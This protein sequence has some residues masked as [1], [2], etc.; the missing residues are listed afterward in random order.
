MIQGHRYL[1]PPILPL[2][3]MHCW[4][5]T[6]K[7]F[8]IKSTSDIVVLQIG[9]ALISDYKS[10]F[11]YCVRSMSN[12][13]VARIR[14]IGASDARAGFPS[15][16]LK[17]A[18]SPHWWG[19][20]YHGQLSNTE[21]ASKCWGDRLFFFF[22]SHTGGQ[23]VSDLFLSTE[24]FLVVVSDATGVELFF[25][26]RTVS[27]SGSA[28]RFCAALPPSPFPFGGSCLETTPKKNWDL[29]IFFLE[30]LDGWSLSYMSGRCTGY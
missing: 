2:Q 29:T 14:L 23:P 13:N 27:D 7:F 5:S 19:K 24:P 15:Y 3:L 11:W 12:T 26:A 30:R 4:Q 18:E 9:R 8:V 6:S 17:H 10:V 28:R 22:P 1:E 25:L 21:Y 16:H 20:D